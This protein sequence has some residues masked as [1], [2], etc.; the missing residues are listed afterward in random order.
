LQCLTRLIMGGSPFPSHPTVRAVF[1]HTAVRQS[2][3]PGMPRRS[4]VPDHPAANVENASG[5]QGTIRRVLPS[6]PPAFPA[7]GQGASKASI[8]ASLQG[9]K[10]LAGIGVARGVPPS[11]HH[12]MH[13]LHTFLRRNRGAPFGAGRSSPPHAAW[14][15]CAGKDRERL[16]PTGRAASLHAVHSEA[17]KARR[18]F[19]D[20]C[21]VAIARQ[22]PP[23][24]HRCKRLERLLR[25]CTPDQDGLLGRAMQR[26]TPFLR[27]AP[28]MPDVIQQVQGD[29]ALQR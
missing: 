14:R 3:C 23:D 1:P 5:I 6:E 17:G 26:G 9:S 18:Q 19:R 12:L 16:L 2:A 24:R 20:A 29:V 4:L 13:L 28:R 21:L 27:R 25:A 8:E 7:T 11:P 10:G 15:R 22:T